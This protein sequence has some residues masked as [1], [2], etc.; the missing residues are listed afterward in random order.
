MPARARPS[1]REC[2]SVA[3]ESGAEKRPTARRRNSLDTMSAAAV[4]H[5][6]PAHLV[7]CVMALLLRPDREDRSAR[8]V[9]RACRLQRQR[10]QGGATPP[11]AETTRVSDQS[12]G[13]TPLDGGLARGHVELAVEALGVALDGVDGEEHLGADLALRQLTLQ[14][15]Q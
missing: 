8:L 12:E 2:V 15:T 9:C 13:S 5:R 3:A 7:I 4:R 10:G 1:V 14:G 11:V 6:V